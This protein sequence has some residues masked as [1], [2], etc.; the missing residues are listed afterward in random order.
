MHKKL[1]LDKDY[2]AKSALPFLLPLAVEPGLNI[3]Q[4]RKFKFDLVIPSLLLD[5][6]YCT[7]YSVFT[8]AFDKEMVQIINT[9]FFYCV[10]FKPLQTAWILSN[11][12]P[13]KL[14]V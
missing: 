3:T 5:I 8:Q 1:S 11:E 4:V 9:V 7:V 6:A 2:I 14:T 10:L 13:N 12:I